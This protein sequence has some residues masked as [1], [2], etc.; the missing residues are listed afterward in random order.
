MR[1]RPRSRHQ[2]SIVHPTSHLCPGVGGLEV[3]RLIKRGLGLCKGTPKSLFEPQ[4]SYVELT[5]GHP[6]PAPAPTQ[7]LLR[8]ARSILLTSIAS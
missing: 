4:F 5:K 1:F 2:T 8:N 6:S 7:W 3:K